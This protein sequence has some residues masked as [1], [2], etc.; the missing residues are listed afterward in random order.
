MLGNVFLVCKQ[1]F[2]HNVRSLEMGIGGVRQRFWAVTGNMVGR[3]GF[4]MAGPRGAWAPRTPAACCPSPRTAH[5]QCRHASW[6]CTTCFQG[7]LLDP[8]V[9]RAPWKWLLVERAVCILYIARNL[10]CPCGLSGAF[11]FKPFWSKWFLIEML[12]SLSCELG[13]VYSMDE[14]ST[15][16][17]YRAL[18]EMPGIINRPK[19]ILTFY[20]VLLL[21]ERSTCFPPQPPNSEFFVFSRT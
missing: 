21:L 2:L 20:P 17:M 1:C 16:L 10:S 12:L 9:L 18:R 6:K 8:S 14:D 7:L 19:L 4:L 11:F 3:T 15:E 13:K 5:R